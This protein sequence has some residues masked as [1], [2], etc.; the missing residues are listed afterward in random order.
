MWKDT[1]SAQF[2]VIRPKPCRN[3]AFPQN[4]HTLKIGKI[5][6]FYAVEQFRRANQRRPNPKRPR[7]GVKNIE[8]RDRKRDINIKQLIPQPKTAAVKKNGNIA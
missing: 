5:T 1:V 8:G 7:A 6:V 4:F 2:L 3:C